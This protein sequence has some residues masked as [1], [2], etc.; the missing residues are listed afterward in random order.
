MP[1]L[2]EGFSIF[3]NYG[4]WNMIICEVRNIK[5]WIPKNSWLMEYFSQQFSPIS[6]PQMEM[7][8]NS[9]CFRR[10]WQIHTVLTSSMTA[11]ERGARQR[12][13]GHD[14]HHRYRG[15]LVVS[16]WCDRKFW[17][18]TLD[19]TNCVDFYRPVG[20]SRFIVLN[21]MPPFFFQERKVGSW[22]Y[23][24]IRSVIV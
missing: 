14:G 16:S 13:F 7:E 11:K 3:V 10:I 5:R 2:F 1:R 17:H 6:S 22:T 18:P 15:W 23:D 12:T 20:L 8:H 24:S 4:L 9:P 19:I 21:M